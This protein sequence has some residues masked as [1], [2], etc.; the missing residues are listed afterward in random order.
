MSKCNMCQKF[1]ASQVKEPL[2]PV[3]IPAIPWHAIGKALFALNGD[4]H[5]HYKLSEDVLEGV[6]A[7]LD[8]DIVLFIRLDAEANV[9][10]GITAASK[11]TPLM[12]QL[13]DHDRA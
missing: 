13:P 3:D 4:M 10:N 7:L 9:L 8:A 2:Q 1:Q 11:R 5:N 6:A 12:M